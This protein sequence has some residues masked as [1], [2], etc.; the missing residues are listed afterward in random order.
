MVSVAM[1]LE[2]LDGQLGHVIFESDDKAFQVRRFKPQTGSGGGLERTMAVGALAGL[3]EGV[4]VP[5]P[6]FSDRL[7]LR[8]ARA[9]G[10]CKI[11]CIPSG[12]F[13]QSRR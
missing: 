11:P 4:A 13:Q 8:R 10:D 5:P 12:D 2:T 1:D 7:C 9:I 6:A 3:P